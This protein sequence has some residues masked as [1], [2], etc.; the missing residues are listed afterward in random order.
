MPALSSH[1]TLAVALLVACAG[2]EKTGG[3][4]PE[5]VVERVVISPASVA[6]AAGDSFDFAAVA[7]LSD[8]R[9]DS[10]L[11]TWAATGGVVSGAGRYLAGP[12]P[13]TYLVVARTPDLQHADTATVVISGPTGPT[14]AGLAVQPGSLALD[15]G[16][17]AGFTAVGS[18]SDGST[19]AVAASWNATGG[20]ITPGGTYSAGPGA[21]AFQVIAS[22]QGFS[23]T[24]QVTIRDTTTP[25]PTLTAVS[26]TP[27]AVTVDPGSTT[28]FSATGSYSDGS[29]GAVSATWSATGGAV[30]QGGSYLAGATPGAF[31]VIAAVQGRAD[32]A[33]VTIRD[34]TT[35]PPVGTVL[36]TEGFDDAGV[37]SRGWYDNTN[38]AVTAASPHGGAGALQMAWSVGG[39]TPAKGAALRHLFTA[40]DRIYVSYWVKYSANWV[41][42]TLSYHPHEFH[43]ITDQ[44]GA[45]VGP[46]ATHLTTYIE[47]N[48]QNGGVPRLSIQDALNIDTT[49]I[50]V[51]LTAVTEHR[52]V[53]GCNG[54]TDGYPDSCYQSGPQ[55]RNEKIWKAAGPAFQ[56]NPGPGYKGDWHRVEA[57]F[58]LNSIQAG[59]GVADGIAQYWFD[60][61]LLI[62]HQN[63]VFRT[64]QHPTMKFNQ[65]VIAPYIGT[66][67]SV[68]QTM[69]VDDLVLATAR[70]P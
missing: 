67:S 3:M 12:V 15:P 30:S 5:P 20:S 62:D 37:G 60:G 66:G 34:T 44:D 43:V 25:P 70:V 24:A 54:S 40:T 2:P 61:Q 38:P 7:E 8:G 33:L 68:A 13:G 55:W 6:L 65:F 36:V 63:V 27:A 47:Q 4:D 23:D 1:A 46:S 35:P 57:Y 18:F 48:Y 41:G 29:A 28:A 42:S 69:W 10:L 9:S 39:T 49:R 26:V 21:G 53:A 32:T 22:H 45:F 19:A 52:A 56:P 17:S 14:L 51:N 31:R 58:Q 64:A 50:N 16:A 11:P 59:K